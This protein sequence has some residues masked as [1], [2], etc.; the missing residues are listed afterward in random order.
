MAIFESLEEPPPLPTTQVPCLNIFNRYAVGQSRTSRVSSEAIELDCGP[1]D[2]PAGEFL[3]AYAG[4]VAQLTGQEKIAF[5]RDPCSSVAGLQDPARVIVLATRKTRQEPDK[6]AR[7]DIQEQNYDD[8]N[9]DEVQFHLNLA[10]LAGTEQT[11]FSDHEDLFTLNVRSSPETCKLQISVVYPSHLVPSHAIPQLLKTITSHLTRSVASLQ[12]PNINNSKHSPELSELNWPSLG[13][14]PSQSQPF[15]GRSHGPFLLHSAFGA[16]AEQAP[17]TQAIDFVSTLGDSNRPAEHHTLTYGALNTAATRLAAHIHER[18]SNSAGPAHSQF[19]IPIYIST[20]VEL[21]ISYLA[22]LK[23][24]FAFCPIPLDAPASRTAEILRDLT[25]P[26]ILGVGD[27]PSSG[28]WVS[29]QPEPAWIDVTAVSGWRDLSRTDKSNVEELLE[30]NFQPPTITD[31]DLAYLMYTSG[32]TGKPKGVQVTH[33]AVSCSIESHASSIP[34]PSRTSDGFR[35]FQFANPTF[36]PSLMEIFVTLSSGGTLCSA[37]RA[38]MLTDLEG[39]LNEV[40]ATIMM[41]TPS[42]AGLIRPSELLTLKHLWT[43]GEALS[44]TVIDKFARDF[45]LINT[46][47]PTEGAINCTFLGPV[48]NGIRGSIIGGPLPTCSMLVIDPNSDSPS[49]V[50]VGCVGE[51]ALAGPQVSRGYLNREA[52]TAKAFVDS[53]E[54]GR[55]YR[56]GDMAR[57]VWGQSGELLIDF[58]GRIL[59]DQAKLS[60]RRVELGEIESL[61]ATVDGV[62]EVVTV[63]VKRD[64]EEIGSER[65]VACIVS[66]GQTD[67]DKRDLVD[68]CCQTVNHHL[69]SYMRP[70]AYL[71]LPKLPRLTSGKTDRKAI[72]SLLLRGNDNLDIYQSDMSAAVGDGQE[73]DS[74]NNEV[75]SIVVEALAQAVGEKASAIQPGASLHALGLDSLGAMKLLQKLRDNSIHDLGVAGVLR[76]QTP[77]ALVALAVQSIESTELREEHKNHLA[78]TEETPRQELNLFSDRNITTCAGRLQLGE[79]DIEK[80][81]P[82][83]ATQ[84]GMLASYLRSSAASTPTTRSYIYHSVMS[85]KPEAGLDRLKQAWDTVIQSY[86]SFRTVFCWLDDDLAPFA[87]CILDSKASRHPGWNIY[88]AVK[89][90]TQADEKTELALRTAE[91]NIDIQRHP[92]QLSL[93]YLEDQVCLILS[94]FHGIFDGGSLQLLL[95][96]VSAVYTG[97]DSLPRT[98]LDHIVDHHFM[99]DHASTAEFWNRQLEGYVPVDFPSLSSTRPP[100]SPAT[101]AVEVCSQVGYDQLKQGSKM[102]ATTPLSVV[103]AAWSSILL[104]YTGA[105]GHD[106]VFGSVVSGRLDEKSEVCIGPTFTTVPIRLNLHKVPKGGENFDSRS[107]AK[108]LASLN[109]DAMTYLQPR[110]GSVVTAEGR[111]PYD[112]LLAY[113]DFSAK[114]TSPAIWQSIHHPAM[115]N[116]FAVMIEVWPGE[117]STLTLRATFSEKVMDRAAAEMMLAEMDSIIASILNS[118]GDNFLETSAIDDGRLKSGLDL[119]APPSSMVFDSMLLH[120]AFEQHV[121]FNPD[122]LALIFKRALADEANTANISWTYRE[123]NSRAQA[124]AAQLHSGHYELCPGSVVPICIQKSPALYVAILAILKAGCAWCPIDVSSPPQRRSNLI[125]R[126]GSRVLLVSS[127]DTIDAA[128]LLPDG[129]QPL[130]VSPFT[131]Q[132]LSLLPDHQPLMAHETK[133]SNMAYLIWTSGTTG[134][135]KGVPITHSAGVASI[136]SLMK[137]IP[138]GASGTPRTLQLSDSI[139]DVSIQDIFYTWSS[140]GTLIS[141]SREIMLGSFPQLANETK[142]THV[143]LTPAFAAGIRRSACKTLQVITMIGE[144]LP[145]PVADDWGTDMRA[146]N[147]YGPAEATIVSTVREFGNEHSSVKSANIGWPLDTVSVFV[148]KGEKLLMKHAVGELALGGPQLSPGYLAQEEITKAKYRWNE[149]VSQILYYTGDLVRM[150]SD[151]SLE[152]LHRV[153]D[154]VKL[155][156]IRVEL[157]EISYTLA[158]SHPL[159]DTVETLVLNRPDR[160]T[161]VVVSF[162]SA[163]QAVVGIDHSGEAIVDELGASIASAALKA[164]SSSLPPHMIPSCCIVI[165]SIPRTQSGKTDRRALQAIYVGLDIDSWDQALGLSSDGSLQSIS[166]S[167]STPLNGRITSTVSA[168]ANVKQSLITGASRLATLGIDSIRAIRLASRLNENGDK[169]SVQDVLQCRTVADLV[170]RV[171]LAPEQDQE[172]YDLEAFNSQWHD[173][174]ASA[175][176]GDF[177]VAPATAIQEGTLSETMSNVAMYWSSHFF[178]LDPSVDLN[179]LKEAWHAVCQSNAALRTGFVSIAA[180][181]EQAVEGS[182]KHDLLQVL[183]NQHDIDWAYTECTQASYRSVLEDRVNDIMAKHQNSYF[184]Q[185]PWAITVL[186]KEDEQ[187]LVLTLHHSIHDGPSL[188]FIKNDVYSAYQSSAPT[189]PSLQQALS[190]ALPTPTQKQETSDFWRAELEPFANAGPPA[191]AELTGKRVRNGIVPK[192]SFISESISLSESASALRTKAAGLGVA[193]VAS[194]LR[195]AWGIVLLA[196]L[197]DTATVFAETLSDRVLDAE[198]AEVIGPFIS[199]VPVPFHAK[200]TVRELFDEQGRTYERSWTHRHVHPREI[201]KALKRAP[202]QSVYPAVFTFHPSSEGGS[203]SRTAIWEEREDEL[204]L[205]VEH[206]F[207]L[208]ASEETDGTL[209]IIVSC[210]STI[211]SATHLN[212]FGRHIDAVVSAMLAHPDE[213]VHEISRFL[214]T[215]L[216]SISGPDPSP[217]VKE[218]VSWSPAYWLEANAKTN[219]DWPA[220]EVATS[221]TDKGVVKDS[222]SYARLDSEANKVAAYLASRGFQNR[223]IAVCGTPSLLLYPITLGIFKSGNAYMPIDEGLPEDRKFVMIEDGNSPIV[224]TESS[225][226]HTFANIPQTCEAIRFDDQSFQDILSQMPSEDQS[227]PAELNDPAYVLFTS[228]STG[229]PK[230]VVVTRGNLSSFLQSWSELVMRIAPD[231]LS[232]GGRGRFLALAN[233]AFDPHIAEMFGPWCFGMATCAADRTLLL[234]DLQGALVQWDITHASFVPSVL[235]QMNILPSDVPKLRYIS[236]GG[237]KISQRVLDTWVADTGVSLVNAYGPTEVTI[238]CTFAHVNEDTNMRN[239]GTPLSACTCHVLVPDSLHHAL[240]GQVGELCFTGS[241]VAKGYM[242]RPDAK[243]FVTGPNGEHMYRTGDMGRMMADGSIEYFGRSDDQTKIRGQRLELGEVSEVVRASSPVAVDVVSMIVKHPALARSQ[244]VSFIAR[245]V[246]NK[247][248]ELAIIYPDIATLANDL[249]RACE[250]RLPVYMVPEI[251]LPITNIPLARLSGKADS[252]ELRRIFGTLSLDEVLRG[253]SL[254]S[255]SDAPV[256]DRALT[257]EEERIIEE[258]ARI[259][260]IDGSLIKP[261][262]NIFEIG[263]DSLGVIG[264]SVRL[265]AAGYDASVA[266]IMNSPVVEQLALLPKRDDNISAQTADKDWE[267]RLNSLKSKFIEMHPEAVNTQVSVRPC[268]PLQEGLVAR[269]MNN[270][271][272]DLYVNH[273]LLKLKEDVQPDLLQSAWSVAAANNEILRTAFAALDSEIVQI[274]FPAEGSTLEWAQQRF[275][276]IEQAK[277]SFISQYRSIA[278]NIIQNISTTPPV[279]FNVASSQSGQPLLLLVSMHHSLYDGESFGMLLD[280]V[281]KHYAGVSPPE[282]GSPSAFIQHVHSQSLDKSKSHWEE[283]LS[284]CSPTLFRNDTSDVGEPVTIDR[285]SISALSD[286]KRYAANLRTTVPSLMQ[287]IF[288]LL[289]ADSINSSD[290]TYGLVLSGRSV[291]VPGAESVLLPCITTI[292]ARLNTKGLNTVEEVIAYAQRTSANSL[293]YQH[294]SLRYIQQWVNSGKPVFDCLFSFVKTTQPPVNAPWEELASDMPMEYPL[295]LEVEADEAQDQL[296]LHCGFTSAFGSRSR[297][298]NLVEKMDVVLSTIINGESLSLESFNL[299]QTSIQTNKPEEKVWNDNA[300]SQLE[301]SIRQIVADFCGLGIDVVLKGTSFLRLGVDSVTAIQL[302][303]RLRTDGVPVSSRDIMRYSCVGALAQNVLEKTNSVPHAAE[304]AKKS[305]ILDISAYASHARLLNSQD[306]I[307][308]I[309][310][311]TPLQSSMITQTLGL[312]GAVYVHPHIVKLSE[313]CNVDTLASALQKV[314]DANDILRTSFHFIQELGGQWVGAVHSQ[315]CPEWQESSISADGDV[316]A[317]ALDVLRLDEESAF[318]IPPL[319]AAIIHRSSE[320]FFA[321]VTH[322][323]LYDGTSLRFIFEDLMLAHQG[324]PLP[325]RSRFADSA[326]RISQ[327]QEEACT[328]WTESL[329]GYKV[330]EVP[331]LPESDSSPHMFF[332][333]ARVELDISSIANACQALEVTVQTAALLSYAKVIAKLTGQRDVVFGHVLARRSGDALDEDQTIGPL[334]NTVAQRIDLGSKLTTNREM[335]QRLQRFSADSQDFQHASLRTIQTRLREARQLDTASVFDTLFVFQKS[336]E[337]PGSLSEPNSLWTPFNSAE[338]LDGQAQ[339]KLNVEVDHGDDG[340]VVR[341]SCQGQFL[342]QRNLDD[343]LKAFSLAFSDTIIQPSRSVTAYPDCFDHL[344]SPTASAAKEAVVDSEEPSHEPI[345]RKVLSEIS[346]VPIDA[347]QPNSS[348]FSIGLDSVS[349][350]RVASE[351]RLQGL[352]A[353]VADVLQGSTVRGISSRLQLSIKKQ[354]SLQRPLI[355]DMDQIR[356]RVLEQIQRSAEE[357]E[358]IL[359]C[360]NG[361]MYHLASWLKS[362]RTLFEPAWPYACSQ[363]IDIDR[364]QNAWTQLRQQNSIL[365]TCFAAVSPSRAVQ[366]VLKTASHDDTFEVISSSECLVEAAQTWAKIESI[367]PSTLHSPPVR[368]RLIKAA[369]RDGFLLL[370]NH[371]AYDAWSMPMIVQQLADIYLGVSSESGPEFA[372]FVN[373]TTQSAKVLDQDSYWDSVIGESSPTLLGSSYTNG[374]HTNGTGSSHR[375]S[376]LFVGSWE[377]IPNLPYLERT[378]QAAGVS[379]QSVTLL[380]VSRVLARLA[381]V[382]SPTFGLYQSGRSA[383]FSGIEGLAGPCLNVT[384]FTAR[385]VLSTDRPLASDTVNAVRSIQGS[386][387]DLIPYEQTSLRDILTNWAHKNPATPVLFNAWVNL[388]WTGQPAPQSAS[389]TLFEPVPIGVPTDFILSTAPARLATEKTSVDALDTTYLPGQNIFIDIGP[390]PRTQTIGF[391]V[392]VEGGLMSESETRTFIDGVAYEIEGLV[393]SLER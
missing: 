86:D 340:I 286:I 202:G 51:L 73:W 136:A 137:T 280:D 234:D 120:S 44:Q 211:M 179:R 228:G 206:S 353:G 102:M 188:D 357:V 114:G 388:L 193:S 216:L 142:A 363:R 337:G 207:A 149:N 118:P 27:E 110:L 189:R 246:R 259:G 92:W 236:V 243:G 345:V 133:S 97:Q 344:P 125:A 166:D 35:W 66:A 261:H 290:I 355:P 49:P 221:I 132:S 187:V 164:A 292:P 165:S 11:L 204:G 10:Q 198:M 376:Q 101:H 373:F 284:G 343:T 305:E 380:A 12:L 41:A 267:Q 139:F 247:G 93:V 113:Q 331:P 25:S 197:G 375:T 103:Q 1:T 208:N 372:S 177:Q 370:V 150:L 130:N 209:T 362:R 70:S 20:S 230:G 98:S 311:C 310:K 384:P 297:V 192:R 154:I 296:H 323:S 57:V 124:L 5:V 231:T 180:L 272:E 159:I 106:V 158:D 160:P 379:L 96:D 258:I 161:N 48:E 79:A 219:P 294:T 151:G 89:G 347:L 346:G 8:Y 275:D 264:L 82:T 326:H 77:V 31:N 39:A 334:F 162:L 274:V 283:E 2:P 218:S 238:G 63:V 146:F 382:P 80:V 134:A 309:F 19:I 293:E 227:D 108:H 157:S 26:V 83:T 141:A 61:L 30:I 22:V 333:E 391:G 255:A 153:D 295:A 46:Y 78:K 18:I 328:F 9:K 168:F 213:P 42:L 107:V 15:N 301:Q 298:D 365:R 320:R 268:L 222:M 64:Q 122:A 389:A 245:S 14:P 229:K 43:M 266:A 7:F 143:H 32:S 71:F 155:G 257:A 315:Y 335:L 367:R 321:L 239:I 84:S 148:T 67:A 392:R 76:A 359:P 220:V 306:T 36:D 324:L 53:P 138:L 72:G 214:P 212:L 352:A 377:K 282:R 252:K 140:G 383:A 225:L 74:S 330:T 131:N 253:N 349:A 185:P 210:L 317:T 33:K 369:D 37:S 47:G 378:C 91:R 183:Y 28:P 21:Y 68:R 281:A 302:S 223:L 3:Q 121:E 240:R 181:E 285:T 167:S 56:T 156:G 288:A 128:E 145:Q 195:A 52:E 270:D 115:V 318:S 17:H 385:D 356:P 354:D 279:R 196:H 171:E 126:T 172:R 251:V 175:V 250:K 299:S 233:R 371:A 374:T 332:S 265:R 341:A 58:L 194:V 269:S 186:A 244:L 16:W 40:K 24:G 178:A 81:L 55:I 199:I 307:E 314:I 390:D 205:N 38:L 263:I 276:G 273:V 260:T 381:Q 360:L 358:Q 6:A 117:N 62:A 88:A 387:A 176:T 224:F 351:L 319:R 386:L 54:F 163:P 316:D 59:S 271:D 90:D 129:C 262:T 13:K 322:H 104:A 174:V 87:Q 287:S 342:S 111:L 29:E 217:A 75:R 278:R 291:S 368:L 182:S 60:G 308:G 300:W 50:P 69:I 312:S 232:L 34:L 147:T 112:T 170:N 123:L 254:V 184:I 4:F 119:A 277:G 45:T 303:K 23:A 95:D 364:M 65:V 109:T 99:A 94:M 366:V 215:D 325:R 191:W 100:A 327:G 173:A 235:D 248:A 289:L 304:P 361:Q 200:G 203:S 152:Y 338:A 116:D 242:D 127:E 105:N 201:R 393:R 190:L 339:Y 241:I 144:K 329:Q 237:E 348:I 135:P 313:T 85:L 169:I 249:R 226:Y 350:I 256:V 336:A